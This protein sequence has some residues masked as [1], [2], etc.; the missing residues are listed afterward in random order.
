MER[1]AMVIRYMNN[2]QNDKL[3]KAIKNN[4]KNKKNFNLSP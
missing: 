1:I 4:G 2:T 3:F